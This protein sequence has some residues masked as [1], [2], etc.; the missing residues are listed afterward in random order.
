MRSVLDHCALC[1][2]LLLGNCY[3][4]PF[5][6]TSIAINCSAN[7]LDLVFALGL[8]IWIY[9]SL[10]GCWLSEWTWRNLAWALLDL[11]WMVELGLEWLGLG[12]SICIF[13]QVVAVVVDYSLATL[14]NNCTPFLPESYCLLLNFRTDCSCIDLCAI[15]LVMHVVKS[16]T[17]VILGCHRSCSMEIETTASLH[18]R[19]LWRSSEGQICLN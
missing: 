18:A 11:V 2:P 17:L 13:V 3:T 10:P 8:L 7:N 4:S 9:Y 6:L 19:L 16:N 1:K 5:L 14:E 12:E 15:D